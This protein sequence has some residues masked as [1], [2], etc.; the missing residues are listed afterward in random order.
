MIK[1]NGLKEKQLKYGFS[2]QDLNLHKTLRKIDILFLKYVK[3]SDLNLYNK[4][5][6]YRIKKVYSSNLVIKT[7]VYLQK[8]IL[9]LFFIEKNIQDDIDAKIIFQCRRKIIYYLKPTIISNEEIS[10]VKNILTKNNIDFK[11][12]IE[13]ASSFKKYNSNQEIILA[14][15]KYCTWVISD[16]KK[17]KI[18]LHDTLFDVPKKIDHNKLIP[19]LNQDGKTISIKQEETKI[20]FDLRNQLSNNIEAIT[21]ACYCL[22]CHKRGKDSCRKGLIKNDFP[23]VSIKGCPLDQ[24]IS[25]MNF[26]KSNNLTL[27]ALAVCMIDNPL[28]ALTGNSICTDCIKSCIFQKQTAVN[29]PL[30]ESTI[31][32]EII[33]LKYGIEIYNLLTKWN[34]LKYTDYL[35]KQYNKINIIVVGAGPGGIA[36]S[37]YL[38]HQGYTVINIEGQKVENLVNKSKTFNPIKEFKTLN[39]NLS[40]RTPLGFG[41]TSEYGVTSRWNKNYLNIVKIILERNQNYKIYGNCRFGSNI[42]Y[43]DIQKLQISHVALATG[44]SQNNIPNIN[45]ISVKGIK[46]SSE[47][48]MSLYSLGAYQIKSLVN[49]QI[50]TP[51]TIVGGG[52]TSIDVATECIAYYPVMLRKFYNKYKI[53]KN[54]II[55][56]EEEID[57]I[58]ELIQHVKI[59][60]K[61]GTETLI[62]KC[63]T[64]KIIYRNSI[65]NSPAYKFNHKE[66]EKVLK[67][68]VRFIENSQVNSINIDEYG[69]IK[70]IHLNDQEINTRTLI[71]ATGTLNDITKLIQEITKIKINDDDLRLLTN[72]NFLIAKTKE[73]NLSIHGDLHPQYSG[74]I[75]KA[76]ASAKNSYHQIINNIKHRTKNN[77]IFNHLDTLLTSKIVKIY[78]DKKNVELTINSPLAA[79]N[80]LPGQFFKLQKFIYQNQNNTN[81]IQN[82]IEP[83][84]VT[85]TNA[86]KNKGNITININIV[87][88]SSFL[89]R[90]FKIGEKISLMGPIGEP[91]V[92]D[93][94]QKVI[95][96]VEG[97]GSIILKSIINDLYKKKCYIAC[98]ANYKYRNVISQQKEFLLVNEII[99]SDN[100][101]VNIK[102][103]NKVKLNDYN[104][105][106]IAT[107]HSTMYEI[108]KILKEDHL[109][110]NNIKVYSFIN[111]TMQCM[112][113]GTCGQCIRKEIHKNNN[114]VSYAYTCKKQYQDCRKID[115]KSLKHK[116]EQN[117]LMEKIQYKYILNKIH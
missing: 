59:L 110:S 72:N 23:S 8:F 35:P 54:D 83:I 64:I 96:I 107:T 87:G 62:K 42:K 98:F 3:R 51:I 68:G 89:C 7:A 61:Y 94:H 73:F 113:Q 65:T 22:H 48:L 34:P 92:I 49:L 106:I 105:I 112:M 45:N 19:N 63:L 75:V 32:Y 101:V 43:Q 77:D 81:N 108:T 100:L 117:S 20:N 2:F 1:C 71:L 50:R 46:T 16:K 27:A 25:E 82:N 104:T 41:G 67:Y 12:Q 11:S 60:K 36:L 114:N 17:R 53:Y 13:I 99:Y 57:I 55:F 14:L 80:F 111:A 18:H 10:N 97:I 28:L 95:L 9:D 33:N 103:Y 58:Q 26:L 5:T 40:K 109:F 38:I 44:A 39:I 115:L 79:Y 91:I 56:N 76:I 102:L 85:A 86:D 29:T 116:L 6:E 24:K 93:K 52:L 15:K 4:I 30:I 21:N 90:N 47:F 69:A 37:Y 70:S 31:F 84:A 88:A 78:Y 74:S 66:L